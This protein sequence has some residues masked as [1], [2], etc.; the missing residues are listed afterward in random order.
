MI[1]DEPSTSFIEVEKIYI[2]FNVSLIL[3]V[4]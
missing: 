1:A 2:Q 3:F 4:V